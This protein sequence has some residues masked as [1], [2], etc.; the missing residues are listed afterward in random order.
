ML[1][2]LLIT[3]YILTVSEVISGVLDWLLQWFSSKCSSVVHDQTVLLW[4]IHMYSV[5]VSQVQRLHPTTL[6]L[7]WSIVVQSQ[8]GFV[9]HRWQVVHLVVGLHQVLSFMHHS[10]FCDSCHDQNILGLGGCWWLNLSF[11]MQ[12][13]VV[14]PRFT[15]YLIC[16]VFWVVQLIPI[17]WGQIYLNSLPYLLKSSIMSGGFICVIAEILSE[18][19]FSP[20]GVSL[21]LKNSQFC[22]LNC[23]FLE[24]SMRLFCLAVSKSA[25]TLPLCFLI[26][27]PCV[28]MLSAIPMTPGSSLMTLSHLSWNT[29]L[30]TFNPKGSLIYQNL[31]NGVLKVVSRLDHRSRVTCEYP[32]VTSC[33]VI[34]WAFD[35]C[36][37]MSSNVLEYHWFL[38][39]A[40]SLLD[41]SIVW[42]F[43]LV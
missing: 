26:V 8:L 29:S 15:S 3:Y 19:T 38:L 42:C 25:M 24:Y 4:W 17:A 5:L 32:D 31:P 22:D 11:Q 37:K 1:H 30:V 9:M 27:D 39:I 7:C 12:F 14:N 23:I 18:S 34:A 41:P 2:E 10:E 16:I 40:L 43:H 36:G 33:R 35:R 6:F 28:R 20:F 13:V 21:C